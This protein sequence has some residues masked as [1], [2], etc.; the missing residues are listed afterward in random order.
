M[1]KNFTPFLIR[2]VPV[3]VTVFVQTT[4]TAQTIT[5]PP[6][7]ASIE[8][9]NP[10]VSNNM[11]LV[12]EANPAAEAYTEVATMAGV[13]CRRIPSGKF[14]YIS[15]NR[16]TIPTAQNNLLIA[17]TYYGNSAN[18]IWFNYNGTSNNYQGAD[19]QKVKN[20]QWVTTIV[21]ITDGALN[22]LMNAGS[23]F[24]MGFNGEDNYI[25]EIKVY[26][27]V[28][29]PLS[30]AIPP[31]I[32]NP[33]A[34]FSDKSFA[35][36]QI[37]HKAGNNA[38]DWV[39]WSYGVI[40]AAGFH[41]NED[42]ASFPDL[43]EYATTETYPTNFAS[44]GNG[45][46]TRL[47][48]STDASI[49]NK[50]MGWLQTAG[51]DGVAVQRFV[52]PI[53]RSIT[54][55]S[56]SHLTN[57]KNACE[58]TGRL[59]YICYD[60]NGS[61]P[62]IV[63]RMQMDW[64]YEIEQMRALTSSPNYATV[65]GKPVV[66]IWGVGYEQASAVQCAGMIS[67]LQAR[68]CYVVGGT[69]REWRTNPATGFTSVFQSLDAVSPWTVG[70]YNDITGA[71]NYLTNFMIAD[72]AYC[73]TNG[74]DYLP[75]AFAGSANWV[76]TDFTLSQTDRLGGNLLWQQVVN[77]KSIGQTSVYYAMLD[78]FEESTNLIKGAIDYFDI[79]TDQYFETFAKDGVWTSSDYYLRLAAVGAQLLRGTVPVT[80]T[81]PIEHSLGPIYFRNS[82]ESRFTTIRTEGRPLDRTLKIDPCFYNPATISTTGITSPTVAIVNEPAFTK[83]GLYSVKAMGTPNSASASEHYYK[84]SEVKITVKANMQLSFWKYSL[85]TLGQYTSIDLVFQSGKRLKNLPAYLDNNGNVMSPAIGRGTVGVWQKFTCQIGVGEL[86]GEVITGILV[87][88]EHPSTTGSY[89][90]YFD[91][92][93]IEDALAV[94]PVQTPYG[95]IV[96]PVPGKIEA[97]NFDIG[98][99]GIAYHDNEA[100][101]LFN[102]FRTSE[103]VD[104]ESTS[105]VGG[106]YN[107]GWIQTGEWLEY[108]V[109]VQTAGTY[110]VEARIASANAG[111]KTL[112]VEMDGVDVSGLLSSTTTAG[113]QNFQTIS[114]TTS[115]LTAG[116]KIMRI[117]I[118]AGEF[119]L[120][121]VNFIL[122]TSLPVTFTSLTADRLSNSQVE[123]KWKVADETELSH[124]EVERSF[125]G[126]GF[127]T[128]SVIETPGQIIYS[129]TD[130]QASQGYNYYRVKT[131]SHNNQN[132]YTPIVKVEPIY[133]N[134]SIIVFPN[135]LTTGFLKIMF[136][137]IQPGTYTIKLYNYLGQ[138]I[139]NSSVKIVEDKVINSVPLEENI[140]AGYYQLE[141]MG[142]DG[143]RFITKLIIE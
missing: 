45:T 63:Q 48:N 131:V 3:L 135:P 44:L 47:Y 82:F 118:D 114:V 133:P 11:S 92:I 95:G 85:N 127:T 72:K 112:H 38:A 1:K 96:W 6:V 55:T 137:E 91:D 19:F 139:V 110:I 36:Y 77:A 46:A 50:Q 25:K 16:P 99:E 59:F 43:S 100:A 17:V 54:I 32:N 141:V 119:N 69:P 56:E 79:P 42:I 5:L 74:M 87:G 138:E 23:D 94:T 86:I 102:V 97:E 115:V 2:V 116:T 70:A 107:L 90:A 109:D 88:Y 67:F 89:T 35:G 41:I 98:G 29:D 80:T 121:Y 4:L 142:E 53:G 101:N 143:V 124:Y 103:G 39:H 128:I 108:S 34:A 65:N 134:G 93:I 40:P 12:I 26:K 60:L 21:T 66:E 106:G 81:I 140:S 78:E 33:A 14:M 117:A 10:I 120:N 130:Q 132:E 57:V 7:S 122:S 13:P 62:T 64:V 51:L 20:N 61:D 37:W 22:G 84:M 136:E 83:T 31:Q 129:L 27:G 123:L 9:T 24:R 30:Q 75:V 58:A 49:I 111:T 68:G 18:N 73:N 104:A 113:W 126:T 28:L 71:N 15:C 8:F 105:D 125:D 76:N 52:G